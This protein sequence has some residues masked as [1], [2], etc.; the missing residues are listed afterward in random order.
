MVATVLVSKLRRCV[1]CRTVEGLPWWGYV[2]SPL[3]AFRVGGG[4]GAPAHL[5]EEG[6]TPIRIDGGALPLDCG[7]SRAHPP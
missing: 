6:E 2:E 4:H 1:H 5:I 3:G 7:Q